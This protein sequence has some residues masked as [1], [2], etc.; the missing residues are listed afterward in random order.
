MDFLDPI[1][2]K[3][4]T[5]RL[6]T[7][8]VLVAIAVTLA[9]TILIYYAYGF[10]V[11]KQGD[12]VQ[13]GLVF[14]SSQPSGAQL[15]VDGTRVNDTN[16]KLNLAAGSYNLDISR[17]GYSNWRRTIQIEGGSVD[18]YV[19]PFLFPK[20]FKTT[21]MKT[22]E[23]DP[24]LT[25]Q[26]PDRRWL[27]VQPSVDDET[28]FEAF[29]L[30]NNQETVGTPT[31]FKVAPDLVTASSSPVAWEVV[32][33]SNNNR[34][35]LFKRSFTAA[36]TADEKKS[37]Y[38]LV[39]RQRPEGSYNLS[40]KLSVD[41]SVSKVTLLDKKSDSYYIHNTSTETLATAT[42]GDTTLNPVLKDVLSFK[43]HGKDTIV[44]VTSKDAPKDK[45]LAKVYNG[46]NEYTLRAIQQSDLYM[47]DAARFDGDWYM[48]VGSRAESRAFIYKNPVAQISSSKSK[49]AGSLFALRVTDPANVSFSA[50]AQY[51]ALQGAEAFHVYDI[52]REQAYRYTARY[53][54]DAPQPKAPWMDGNRFSYVSGGKQVVFDYDNLNKHT[55]VSASPVYQSAFDRDYEYLYAFA[56]RADGQQGVVLT[57]TSLRTENDL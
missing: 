34:H 22:Y 53:K 24:H 7:G 54:V 50:N 19:Y 23:A 56:P 20:D 55:L 17:D 27:V 1:K 6:F 9:A 44:Y 21:D 13:K 29:D 40:R 35:I 49:K 25:T 46:S 5:R 42:L 36:E 33:W 52:D 4:H 45:V 28:K 48:V 14:V 18:H 37:E 3:K 11:T 16:T 43:S 32:E 51:I 39:D 10:G 41:A 8:Y 15:R 38:I 26:S 57:T 47:L 30:A 2:K 31:T 12:L